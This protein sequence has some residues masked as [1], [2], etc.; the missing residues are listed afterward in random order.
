[1]TYRYFSENR[2][3]LKLYTLP[4]DCDQS[5]GRRFA[6]ILTLDKIKNKTVYLNK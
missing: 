4:V 1:M 3:R 2:G 6:Y 5:R